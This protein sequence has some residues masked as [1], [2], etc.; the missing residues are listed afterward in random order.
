MRPPV[1]PQSLQPGLLPYGQPRAAPKPTFRPAA[2]RLDEQGRE[3]DE[4]GNLVQNRTESITTLKVL[5]TPTAH[6]LLNSL[7]S[8][9][10]RLVHL[11]LKVACADNACLHLLV[12][13][14]IAPIHAHSSSTGAVLAKDSPQG[15]QCTQPMFR[16]LSCWPLSFVLRTSSIIH[17]SSYIDN[18][19]DKPCMG[20]RALLEHKG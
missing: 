20:I 19:D 10:C 7:P 16:L 4:F 13:L 9:Y 18:V 2:L 17:L 5:P 14:A 3:I 6:H 1:P 12:T 11:H 8:L 15:M